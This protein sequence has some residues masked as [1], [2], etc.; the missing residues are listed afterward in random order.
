MKQRTERL[1]VYIESLST[2]GEGIGR[3]NPENASK[4]A[5]HPG[6]GRV[7]FVP[8]ALPGET[9]EVEVYE[10]HKNFMRAKAIE[11][12]GEPAPER[13][14]PPCPHFDNCGGCQ[15]Q[16]LPYSQQLE[17]KRKWIQE[18]FLRIGHL[19]LDIPSPMAMDEFEYRNRMTFDLGVEDRRALAMMHDPWT[20]ATKTI[21]E[22][23][24]LLEPQLSE[25]LAGLRSALD[26]VVEKNTKTVVRG[27]H[28]SR[29]QVRRIGNGIYALIEDFTLRNDQ[30]RR[31]LE[32]L[33]KHG[34]YDGVY[35]VTS[36]R[37]SLSAP[38]VRN[39]YER[40]EP[41][42]TDRGASVFLSPLAFLQVNEPVAAKFYDYQ[43][44]LPVM[45]SPAVLD[46]YAGMGL[47]SRRLNERFEIV[48]GVDRDTATDQI[49]NADDEIPPGVSLI[50]AEVEPALPAFLMRL[51]AETPVYVNPPRAGL[52]T[53]VRQTL[54]EMKPVDVVFASCN[55]ATLARDVE[56]LCEA[57]Y[58][59]LSVQPFDFFPQ[60][61][62]VETV[63]HLQ[64]IKS[65]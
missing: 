42:F 49:L 8:R 4:T 12:C 31:L 34:I 59:V 64:R 38:R 23:C 36:P 33:S 45:E 19:E 65:A 26:A 35:E 54:C 41:R 51:G 28:R 52:S 50:Q 57:G 9:W 22:Q 44:A 56:T 1:R 53:G 3:D 60:T 17:W 32:C 30:K 15:L 24:P 55:P 62:H 11:L 29:I 21:V 40:V 18:T 63:V 5:K 2:E 20:S 16:H 61:H 37:S 13:R 43:A 10:R 46:M 25:A 7:V 27:H 48:I 58:Q 39:L 47:L 14:Q 6:R